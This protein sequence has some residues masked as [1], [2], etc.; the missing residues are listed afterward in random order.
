MFAGRG[1]AN[2]ERE[3]LFGVEGCG[4]PNSRVFQGERIYSGWSL[5][6]TLQLTI[7]IWMVVWSIDFAG[8]SAMPAQDAPRVE[9]I[10][11]HR[12]G[13]AIPPMAIQRLDADIITEVC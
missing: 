1:W 4:G 5:L 10:K 12:H 11:R 2:P 7:L 6:D 8:F 3:G 13:R 9:R